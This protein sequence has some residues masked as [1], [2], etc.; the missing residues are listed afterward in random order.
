MTLNQKDIATFHGTNESIS[1][2]IPG[3]G[4]KICSRIIVNG[5]AQQDL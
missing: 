1:I 5:S 2:E 3:H 4:N